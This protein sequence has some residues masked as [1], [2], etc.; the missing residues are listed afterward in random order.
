MRSGAAT[1]AIPAARSLV[2]N[3]R[4]MQQSEAY[5]GHADKLFDEQSAPS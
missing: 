5:V 4:T 3:V 1:I 2:L